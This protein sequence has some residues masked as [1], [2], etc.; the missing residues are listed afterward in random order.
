M[1]RAPGRVVRATGLGTHG[2]DSEDLETPA[3]LPG[4]APLFSATFR[5][6]LICLLELAESNERLQAARIA[7]KHGLSPHYLAVVLRELR[8]LG[9]IESHKGNRGGYRLLI[10]PERITLLS[11]HRS[12]A[13]SSNTAGTQPVGVA[14]RWLT[15]IAQRWYGELEAITLADLSRQG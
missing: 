3:H 11:L 10:R 9:L 15:A 2:A 13:G 8:R 7:S 5:Y 6:A 12:L 4:S 1:L 14:D